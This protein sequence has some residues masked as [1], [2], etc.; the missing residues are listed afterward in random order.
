MDPT[1]SSLT[2]LVVNG[3]GTTQIQAATTLA[4]NLLVSSGTLDLNG[5]A[6]TMNGTQLEGTVTNSS[7]TAANFTAQTGVLVLQAA[8]SI[9]T[10]NGN[11]LFSSTLSG[12][13][14]GDRRSV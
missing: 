13:S 8:T 12:L 11:I 6:L 9:T 5:F 3:G 4:G 14:S 1:G 7:G 10:G 2:N